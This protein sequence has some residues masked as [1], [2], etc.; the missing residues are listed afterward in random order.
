M[1]RFFLRLA[2]NAV[3]LYVA[4]ALMSGHGIQSQSKDW[5]GILGLA[6][7]FGLINA[8]L[9]PILVVVGC[10]FLVLTLGLGTLLINTLLFYLAGWIGSHF[11]F[12]FS[13]NGFWP[14]FLGAMIV[15]LVS[16]V[17]SKLLKG[18]KRKRD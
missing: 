16:L 9:R 10:P 15:S 17:L 1:K 13:V 4:L 5:L 11:G 18:E 3:A 7:V 12:G 2:I 6:L 14:A 8:I